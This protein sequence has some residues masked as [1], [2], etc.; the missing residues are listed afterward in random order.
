[1]QV[2]PVVNDAQNTHVRA[3][4]DRVQR[5]ADALMRDG[6]TVLGIEIKNRNPIIWIQPSARC[7]R[8]SG[9]MMIRSCN[10]RGHEHVMVALIEGCQAQWRVIQK[11]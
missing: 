5:C 3:S 4:L 1:M 9:E 6:F 7:A 8:L 10:I 11:V 2:Q